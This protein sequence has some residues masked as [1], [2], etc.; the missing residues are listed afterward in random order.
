MPADPVRTYAKIEKD[1]Q[2]VLDHAAGK[3]PN[4]STS[5]AVRRSRNRFAR[6]LIA[7]KLHGSMASVFTFSMRAS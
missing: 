4:K 7:R 5:Y 6:I 3:L 2:H 1:V